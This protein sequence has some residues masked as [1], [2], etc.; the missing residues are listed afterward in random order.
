MIDELEEVLSDLHRERKIGWTRCAICIACKELVR[1]WCAVPI[2][3]KEAGRPTLIFYD[4][5]GFSTWPVPCCLLFY[6]TRG[7]KRE[8]GGSMLNISGPQ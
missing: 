2:L 6:C 1:T 4:A 3:H 5:D 8:D 7:D